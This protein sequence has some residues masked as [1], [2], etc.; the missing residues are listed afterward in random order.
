MDSR[1][2][3]DIILDICRQVNMN[4]DD[5]KKVIKKIIVI[6]L[7]YIPR[8][9]LWNQMF[10]DEF[11]DWNILNNSKDNILK[12]IT[13]WIKLLDLMSWKGMQL[14]GA[15]IKLDVPML[16]TLQEHL[17]EVCMDPGK[18]ETWTMVCKVKILLMLLGIRSKDAIEIFTC[19]VFKKDTSSPTLQLLSLQSDVKYTPEEELACIKFILDHAELDTNILEKNIIITKAAKEEKKMNLQMSRMQVVQGRPRLRDRL[20]KTM[21]NPETVFNAWETYTGFC[22]KHQFP[23]TLSEAIKSKLYFLA[24]QTAWDWRKYVPRVITGSTAIVNKVVE[25]PVAQPDLPVLIAV[26]E[27]L[28]MEGRPPFGT[29]NIFRSKCFQGFPVTHVNKMTVTQFLHL[30]I[31]VYQPVHIWKELW[32]H[33]VGVISVQ[34]IRDCET[35]VKENQFDEHAFMEIFTGNT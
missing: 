26:I 10:P 7:K 16:Q 24:A 17:K 4:T 5:I 12:N 25:Y 3:A 11:V 32:K 13:A 22:Y 18:E 35:F 15:E 34:I 6:S 30:Y 31:S 2:F 9:Q 21:T 29:L 1:L 19:N 33:F 20:T 23:P 28:D 8:E 14:M 27:R